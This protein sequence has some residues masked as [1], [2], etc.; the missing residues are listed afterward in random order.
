MGVLVSGVLRRRP[1]RKPPPYLRTL[2][3][4]LLFALCET[5]IVTIWPP[6]SF[7]SAGLAGFFAFPY[8]VV[9]LGFW[10]F[11]SRP[12]LTAIIIGFGVP[13]PNLHYTLFIL[14]PPLG[15][16]FYERVFW[17]TQTQLLAFRIIFSFHLVALWLFLLI[18]AGVD[19][20]Y[21]RFHVRGVSKQLREPLEGSR[22]ARR[23]NG[24]D[25]N[26]NVSG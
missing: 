4:M 11:W 25:F 12:R 21:R 9:H 7:Q 20:I 23:R 19:I 24:E 8:T 3:V 10:Y 17:E 18:L 5:W 26:R 16:P 6:Y 15:L 22:A 13:I 14:E 1:Q 2:A